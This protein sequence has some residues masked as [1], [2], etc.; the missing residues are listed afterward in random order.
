MIE[1]GAG[2]SAQHGTV[3]TNAQVAVRGADSLLDVASTWK[4]E[5]GGS[6][7]VEGGDEGAEPSLLKGFDR[8][9]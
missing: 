3:Q 6:L 4:V 7:L 1:S 2:F 8:G 9:V 5:P